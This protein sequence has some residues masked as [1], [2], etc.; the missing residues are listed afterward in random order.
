MAQA[1]TI[2]RHTDEGAPQIVEGRP[3]E[4]YDV[5]KKCLVEGFGNKSPLGWTI[6]EEHTDSPFIAF[7]NDI[8][9]GGSGGYFT[10]TA[11]NNN[12][13]QVMIGQSCLD[14][15][16]RDTMFRKGDFKS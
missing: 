11:A 6:T 12:P 16:N 10:I 13:I 4:Y 8:N 7:Q 1:V 3:S 2:C 14:F 9:N 5:F 15:I